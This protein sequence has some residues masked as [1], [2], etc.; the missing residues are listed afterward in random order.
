L[1]KETG[2]TACHAVSRDTL[3]GP[4]WGGLYGEDVTLTD[5][6]SAHVDDAYLTEAIFNPDAQVAAGFSKGIMPS[7]TGILDTEQV[8][9]IV[10]YIRS[11][12]GEG[13]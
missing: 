2:C 3:I 8:A 11:L 12:G 1:V 7:Y 5:G 4:G 10:A 9:A 13:Q 6:S